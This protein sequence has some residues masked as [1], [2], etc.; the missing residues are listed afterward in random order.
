MKR[1]FPA[2]L[3]CCLSAISHSQIVINKYAAVAA[4]LPCDNVFKVDDAAGFA[5]GDTVLVIQM[6]G[7]AIDSGNSAS[8]GAILN[9]NGAGNYEFNVVAAVSGTDITLRYNLKRSY[10]IP[11]GRVQLVRVP[12]FQ[13]YTV[14]QPLTC[15]PWNGNKGG[16]VVLN[17]SGTVTLNAPIDVS[18]KGFRNGNLVYTANG[19][20]PCGKLDYYYANVVNSL[21]AE[22]GEGITELSS[23]RD[24]GRGPQGNGGGGGNSSNGGGGGGSNAGAG[25]L[26][27]KETA[28][29]SC[30]PAQHT[31]GLGGVVM[32]YSNTLNKVFMGGGS[33]AGHANNGHG[34]NGSP[35]GGI[36]LLMAN[37]VIGNG[38]LIKADGGDGVG[39]VGD[40]WDAQPGGSAGGSIL[41]HVSSY[42]GSIL[43][44][45]KGGKGGSHGANNTA[46]GANGPGGGGGGGALWVKGAS[47][48]SQ[49]T[50]TLT[51]GPRG[52]FTNNNDPWGT[53]DGQAGAGI[54]GLTIPFPTDSFKAGGLNIS[55]KDSVVDCF[56]HAMVLL[57]PASTPGMTYSW[58]FGAGNTSTQ[59][60]P[61]FTFPAYGTYT[62]TLTI[63]YG[64]GCSGTVSKVI[65]I[66]PILGS[67]KNITL[68]A[69]SSVLL[70]ASGGNSYSWTPANGL[71][72]PTASSTLASP[73]VTTT[74]VVTVTGSGCTHK[75]TFVVQ[76]S[77]APKADFIFYPTTPVANTPIQFTDKSTN[78]LIR[79]WTF[80]DGTASDAADP[81]HLYR[82]SG[83]YQVC[84]IVRNGACED[85]ICKSVDALVHVAV[86]VPSG[87][88]PNGDGNNDRLFARGTGVETVN[89]MIFNRWGQKVFESN[90][91]SD[92]W[93]G[94]YNGK[95]QEIDIYAYVLRATFSDGSSTIKKGNTNLLR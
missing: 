55:F 77:P 75:D 54:S 44:S 78:A 41:L 73:A 32:S 80:G 66:S 28:V 42:S 4:Y 60:D 24:H 74:Y 37:Q 30:A 7:A 57:S 36:V 12:Y 31:G 11:A 46:E 83:T 23:N 25:G 20:A 8:F 94:I 53:T 17:A 13:N 61:S 67:Q 72:N 70:S 58:N 81:A 15:M 71:S 26:G 14:S 50:A 38:Q 16:I 76:V 93:D 86:G 84:L 1:L 39:C 40:C 6:K 88:T 45:A 21:G 27:G 51:G 49:I 35:G 63:N 92:G 34:G 65:T 69:G 56:T 43:A 5:V 85:T 64:D 91:L 87:F 95:M 90:S 82:K 68:C 79:L 10:E 48:P 9:Y 59:R 33:G 62:V 18:F 22:K 29:T 47:V 89:L 19:A 52:V 2:L 3:L